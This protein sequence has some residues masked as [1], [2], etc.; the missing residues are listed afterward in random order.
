MSSPDCAGLLLVG[1]VT[2]GAL[3]GRASVL[4]EASA[5]SPVSRA[6]PYEVG[7]RS[8]V[9]AQFA[10]WPEAGGEP[11]DLPLLTW[12]LQEEGEPMELVLAGLDA[13]RRLA[14]L[15]VELLIGPSLAAETWVPS[16]PR[17]DAVDLV[18]RASAL[19]LQGLAAAGL[20]LCADGF[21]A[22]E[23]SQITEAWRAFPHAFA[24]GV[25]AVR[26]DPTPFAQEGAGA[27]C[28]LLRDELGFAGLILA[29]ARTAAEAPRLIAAGCDWVQ[30]QEPEGALDAIEAARAAGELSEKRLAGALGR[31]AAFFGRPIG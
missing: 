7:A 13:G 16:G 23:A 9:A 31:I 29:R 6:E 24:H 19:Y 18:A 17:G 22:M 1:P 8:C 26:L 30:V 15:G 2:D 21:P 3:A 11:P 28:R 5:L 14:A 4:L 27:T 12:E 25:D 10:P 20:L